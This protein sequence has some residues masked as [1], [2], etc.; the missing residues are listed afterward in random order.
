MS[1]R[2]PSV[3]KKDNTNLLADTRSKAGEGGNGAKPVESNIPLHNSAPAD[4]VVQGSHANAQSLLQTAGES[5]TFSLYKLENLK[6]K[7]MSHH[8]HYMLN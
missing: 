1:I 4:L 8:I 2:L 5:E 6:Q 3:I 7:G